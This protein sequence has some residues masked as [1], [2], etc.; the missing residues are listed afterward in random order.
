MYWGVVGLNRYEGYKAEPEPQR[1]PGKSLD[2]RSGC[3][4]VFWLRV[5]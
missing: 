2:L 4:L 5:V 1:E 3:C